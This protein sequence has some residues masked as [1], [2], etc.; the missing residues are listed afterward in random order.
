MT[1][2]IPNI[3]IAG[4]KAVALEVN[5]N[6]SVIK[7]ELNRQSENLNTA[8]SLA[9]KTNTYVNGE[10]KEELKNLIKTAKASFCVNSGNKNANGEADL[11]AIDS[12]S[13][14]RIIFKIGDGKE[15]NM[16]NIVYSNYKGE[17]NTRAS[18]PAVDMTGK[19]NGT[20]NIFAKISG[21]PYALNN[22]IYRQTKRPEMLV[23]DVWMDISAIPVRTVQYNGVDDIEFNDVPLG[24]ATIK[25][26]A[27]NSTLTFPYNQNGFDINSSS[28]IEINTALAKSI[29]HNVMPDYSKGV[30]KTIGTVHT[31][32]VDGFLSAFTYQRN[33][34]GNSINVN[35]ICIW[36]GGINDGDGSAGTTIPIAKGNTFQVNFSN[37]GTAIFYPLIGA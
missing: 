6:F 4:K 20:Y 11:L 28:K 33:G 29:A 15:G 17:Q 9:E 10:L 27:L 26:G 22:K 35:S 13:P 5:E 32:E 21:S 30:S 19:A 3:F 2:T 37:G 14:D 31:A 1:F 34:W 18:L 12:I 36:Q 23:D 16:A 24:Q 8:S 7:N 25:E